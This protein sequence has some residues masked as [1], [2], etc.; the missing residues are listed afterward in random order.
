MPYASWMTDRKAKS[1]TGETTLPTA[2]RHRRLSAV[3]APVRG[4]AK[5]LLGG[6]AAVEAS[7]MLD[8]PAIVGAELAARCQPRKLARGRGA[9]AGAATLHLTVDAP[10]AL[11]I[12][13][14]APQIMERVNRYLGY[15]AVA[16]LALHQG[17]LDREEK[18]RPPRLPPL[19]PPA[20]QQ[21]ERDISGI[22]DE[23]L[24][25]ALDRL[26]Q[27]VLA[28]PGGKR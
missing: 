24:R 21:L 6:K 5:K 4:L 7:V 16:R 26:G 8:W 23:G 19:A 2:V 25:Q 12:Q 9:N 10:F 13:Y 17:T 11:E 28:K 22:A 20:R 1:R 14:S 27:A 15:A 3:A 18:P